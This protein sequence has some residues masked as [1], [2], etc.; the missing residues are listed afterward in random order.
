MRFCELSSWPSLV[1]LVC[2]SSVGLRSGPLFEP[3][4]AAKLLQMLVNMSSSYYSP[5]HYCSL[6][7]NCKSLSFAKSNLAV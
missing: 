3:A 1:R 4:S 2:R 7:F 5:G 6:A